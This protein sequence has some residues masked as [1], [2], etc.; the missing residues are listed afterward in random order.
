MKNVNVNLDGRV[1]NVTIAFHVLP[2]VVVIKA[3]VLVIPLVLATASVMMA[4]LAQP[5][6]MCCVTTSA[7]AMVNASICSVCARMDSMAP[8]VRLVHHAPTTAM[9]MVN[10][11]MMRRID[12]LSVT[13][14]TC[15]IVR[16]AR[17]TAPYSV[18]RHGWIRMVDCNTNVRSHTMV[19]YVRRRS[20]RSHVRMEENVRRMVYV[21]VPWVGRAMIAVSPS[22]RRVVVMVVSVTFMRSNV[23]ASMVIVVQP[24]R[25]S[26]MM[27]VCPPAPSVAVCVVVAA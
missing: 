23:A 17:E 13:V 2:L 24:V 15:G 11:T 27:S 16:R 8:S 21:I 12:D 5:V 6:K 10:A 18:A 4:S 19:T 26:T 9:A 7:Q 20:A 3:S 25:C 1:I 14:M 22:V